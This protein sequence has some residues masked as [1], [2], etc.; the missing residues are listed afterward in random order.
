MNVE[1]NNNITTYIKWSCIKSGQSALKSI[2]PQSN[3][4]P[5]REKCTL[6]INVLDQY[7][8]LHYQYTYTFTYSRTIVM[9]ITWL[10]KI[11]AC[12]WVLVRSICSPLCLHFSVLSFVLVSPSLSVSDLPFPPKKK[13][14]PKQFPSCTAHFQPGLDPHLEQLESICYCKYKFGNL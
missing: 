2:F 10:H 14:S 13:G 4:I 8:L 11:H 7:T 1:I 6:L 5:L 3:R 12:M 9:I